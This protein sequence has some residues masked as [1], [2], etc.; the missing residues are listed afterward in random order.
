MMRVMGDALIVHRSGERLFGKW[1]VC[2]Q[3]G[4]VRRREPLDVPDAEIPKDVVDGGRRL[5]PNDVAKALL[6]LV[7]K[8]QPREFNQD[9]ALFILRDSIKTGAEN[10]HCYS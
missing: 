4:E 3:I 7:L 10:V 1:C 5:P 8:C 2:D 9:R 6:E